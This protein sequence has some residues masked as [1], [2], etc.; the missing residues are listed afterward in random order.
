MQ[1]LVLPNGGHITDAMDFASCGLQP[2]DTIVLRV[3]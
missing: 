2:G 3:A 1:Q